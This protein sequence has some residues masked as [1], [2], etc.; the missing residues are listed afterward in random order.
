MEFKAEVETKMTTMAEKIEANITHLIKGSMVEIKTTVETTL[1]SQMASFMN[2]LTEKIGG[3]MRPTT[4]KRI[5]KTLVSPSQ[6][7]QRR[8]PTIG[9]GNLQN[10]I[11][12]T[13]EID[14]EDAMHQ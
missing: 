8:D 11:S 9:Q 10:A 13:H 5:R 4:P 12:I 3:E 7:K 6:T 14:N 1:Q 2:N